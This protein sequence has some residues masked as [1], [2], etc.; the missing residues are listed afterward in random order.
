MGED[1]SK[2][3]KLKVYRPL[4]RDGDVVN[5][6]KI[7]E[8]KGLRLEGSSV[9]SHKLTSSSMHALMWDGVWCA[10]IT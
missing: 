4:S 3:N 10:E 6:F 5:L 2:F 9:T 7:I 8:G 1:S